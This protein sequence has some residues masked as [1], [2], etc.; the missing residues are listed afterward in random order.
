MI[1]RFRPARLG[2]AA[3]L[4][5]GASP[6]ALAQQMS[7][8]TEPLPGEIDRDAVEAEEGFLLP[9]IDVDRGAA[10]ARPTSYIY[11]PPNMSLPPAQDNAESLAATPGVSAGRMGGLGG[12]I[13]I[14]GQQGN[15]INVIDNG[16]FTY[17]AC[18][19]RMDPPTASAA[20][21]RADEVIIERGYASVRNGPGATG[22]VVRLERNAPEF[23]DGK[24]YAGEIDGGFQSNGSGLQGSSQLALSL[25]RGFYAELAGEYETASDYED[26]DGSKVRSSFTRES[27]GATFGWVGENADFAVEIDNDHEKDVEYAGSSM[28]SPEVDS[29]VYRL[30]GGVDV[31]WGA[32]SR[33]EGNLFL[34]EVDHVMD[35]YSLRPPPMM[36]MRSPTSSDTWG[37]KL[38]AQFDFG[39][40]RA[41]AGVDF[42]SN[43]RMAVGYMGMLPVV[44][45]ANISDAIT[46]SWPDVTTAQTGLYLQTETQFTESDRLRL[47]VRYD[48]VRADAADA[49]GKPGYT[50][51][52]PNAYY[53]AV[54][55]V[56]F[57]EARTEN[58]VGGLIRYEHDLTPGA[59][60]FVG[61][62]RAMRTADASERAMA[63]GMMGTPTWVGNPDI[64][65]EAH[66]ELDVG[67][68]IQQESWSLNAAAYYDY[69]TD[70]I[71]RDQF[72]TPGLT[73]YRN[74]DAE[75]A[76]VELSGAW[77]MGG[78]LLAG[79]ATYT[80]GQNI[81]D[82]RALAQIPP[83]QGSITASYG[84]DAWTAAARVNWALKQGRIDPSRDP[85]K[86]PGY[87]TLD[88]FG[89]WA[90]TERA[91]LA[92]GVSNVFDATYANHLSRE[93]IFDSTLSQVNEPG[94]SFW[95]RVRATF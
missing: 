6:L 20:F 16:S 3:A 94:R 82:D 57:D 4:F 90:V 93:N 45:A 59:T 85:G 77:G 70:F 5:C 92:F 69:V 41:W 42:Q 38:E 32:F 64:K 65:P 19:S 87:A 56:T 58:N 61:V 10:E 68:E 78:F 79:D 86:T 73:Q 44:E 35:N 39:A 7:L 25:G 52:T 47:G 84:Q 51:T 17:G 88:L 60:A 2:A 83:L 8:P 81:T 74:V 89:T 11:T 29:W 30:R 1:I 76:G 21:Y 9:P 23:E 31:D 67:M 36:A 71:L 18:P 95:L 33:L 28:D 43:T 12:E 14:R 75:L 13:V 40:T 49:N 46:L 15:Q 22:G 55:G 26:G 66:H 24:F 54:Y 27:W 63:R 62:S 53:Q 80:F 72:T 34:S 48:H 91:E 50:A 37:G